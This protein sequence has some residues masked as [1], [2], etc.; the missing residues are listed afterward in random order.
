MTSSAAL[1]R[2][3]WVKSLLLHGSLC[4]IGA[5]L[6][7]SQGLKI[8][9]ENV[10]LE[11]YEIPPTS[12]STLNLQPPAPDKPPPP[13]PGTEKRAVF[14]ASRDAIT[15]ESSD[16]QAASVK[17]G[18]TVTKEPD[19]LELNADDPSSLPIPADDYLVSSLPKLKSEIRIPYPP[20]ARQKGIAGPVV[21]DLLIDEKG[22]VRQV[23]LVKGPGAGLDE[24]ATNA[25][26][27]FEFSPAQ[28]GDKTVAVKI[29]YTYRFVL[30]N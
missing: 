27:N 6:H 29:R 1:A 28:I 26:K 16:T 23:T 3:A 24:A 4:L 10:D 13:P 14:G 18:N 9:T 5:G 7:F 20:E 19:Q 30:E 17:L 22:R 11:V 25:L 2:S 21:M 8:R 12:A 15:A